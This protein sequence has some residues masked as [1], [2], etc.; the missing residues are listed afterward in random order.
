MAA[1]RVDG[2]GLRLFSGH[3]PQSEY[4]VAVLGYVARGEH[5]GNPGMH[6]VVDEHALAHRYPRISGQCDVGTVTRRGQEHLTRQ[7]AAILEHHTGDGR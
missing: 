5:A 2:R 7:G 6:A 3:R 4:L 1:Q